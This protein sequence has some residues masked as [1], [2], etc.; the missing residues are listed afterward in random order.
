[1]RKFSGDYKEFPCDI[2]LSTDAVELPYAR[3]YTKGQE[4]HICKRCGFIYVKMRRPYDKIAQVWSSELFGK[5]YTSRT[6]LMLAR[7]TYIAE[8]INQ[9][10]PL[11][12]KK[13]Y[14]IGAGEGQFLGIV[15]NNYGAVGFGIE[16]SEFNCKIIRKAGINSFCGTLEEYLLSPRV[17]KADAD[18]VTMMWTLENTASCRDL[19]MGARKIL[20][21]NSHIVIATGSRILVPF[22][23]PLGLYL[24][25]NPVDTHPS[26]FS[27]NTL[28][29]LL[30]VASFKTICVNPYLNDS[31][32]L[33]V[34]AKKAAIPKKIRINGDDY[35]KVSDFFRRWHKESLLYGKLQDAKEK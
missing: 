31:L 26:R 17:K 15:R 3:N 12:N 22:S 33:C 19:L 32:M 11:K 6:P 21:K 27:V 16:P 29:A 8:F 1:M 9:H 35:R 18:I 13:I 28:T 7:H 2:C 20:K 34:I 24:S 10:I 30:A 5:A 25:Q 14:D 4:I 23:K